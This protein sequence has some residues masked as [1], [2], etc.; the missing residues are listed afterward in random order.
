MI[1]HVLSDGRKLSSIEGFRIPYNNKTEIIYRA[2]I[3]Q[4]LRGGEQRDKGG[5]ETE[6]PKTQAATTTY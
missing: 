2:V 3:E 5:A 6:I 4:T 1:R